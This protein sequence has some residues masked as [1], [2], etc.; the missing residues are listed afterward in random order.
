[1]TRVIMLYQ[2]GKLP[3]SRVRVLN[4][5]PELSRLGLEVTAQSYPRGLGD[6]LRLLARLGSFDLAVLQKKL[7]TAPDLFLLRRCA[8]KLVFDFDDAIYMRDD[9][10]TSSQ[11]RTRM[12]RFRNLVQNS[13]L[14]L[15]GNPVL[16]AEALKYNQSVQVVPSAVPTAGIVL[17]EWQRPN[18]K[19]VVGWVGGGGNLPHLAIAG[20]ALRRLAQEIDLELRVISNRQF[21]LEGVAVRNVPWSLETQE[22]EIAGFDVGIMP[23]PKNAWTEGKCSYKLLQY[24]AAGV[25][26]VAT[27]WG[28]NKTVVRGGQTGFLADSEDDFYRHMLHL[29]QNPELARAMGEQ[30]R[31]LIEQEYSVTAVAG[32]LAAIFRAA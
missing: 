27:D 6:R 24:M 29:H 25:P 14:V 7:L 23:M 18:S 11:S 31:E 15:A 9:S 19:L 20:P 2:D 13:D 16:A 28:F 22:R 12:G 17:K 32:R 21:S 26:V 3:S 5:V 30:A 1:M 10:A 4:L 8:R